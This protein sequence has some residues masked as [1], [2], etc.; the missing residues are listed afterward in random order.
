MIAKIPTGLIHASAVAIHGAGLLITGPSGCGKSGLALQL[1]ALGADLISD[2]QVLLKQDDREITLHPAPNLSGKIEARYF[3]ILACPSVNRA[4]L[5]LVLSLAEAPQQRLP[6]DQTILVG[7]RKIDFI[8][9]KNVPNLASA[10]LL[11]LR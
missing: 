1:I 5:S 11:H 9:G 8:H 6:Q 4:P 2:D 3:G 7:T 10:V